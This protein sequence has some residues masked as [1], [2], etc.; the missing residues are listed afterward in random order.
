MTTPAAGPAAGTFI[1]QWYVGRQMARIVRT[2]ATTLL[3]DPLTFTP[4]FAA[5]NL[6]QN[7]RYHIDSRIT[8]SAVAGG[9]NTGPVVQVIL[10]GATNAG[11]NLYYQ[12]IQIQ[13]SGVNILSS[14][15]VVAAGGTNA[16]WAVTADA[17]GQFQQFTCVTGSAT[18]AGRAVLIEGN[19]ISPAAP[20]ALTI[21][22]APSA[23][24]Q[25]WNLLALGAYI[26]IAQVVAPTNPA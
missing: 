18:P 5:I 21:Q 11:G 26:S 17:I 8:F 1:D 6:A 25:Q 14:A 16:N 7:V 19:I 10:T 23:A 12:D 15:P 22:V 4:V 24:T 3:S 9:D 13:A 20:C 2:T